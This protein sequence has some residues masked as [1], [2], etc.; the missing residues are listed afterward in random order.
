MR[1]CIAQFGIMRKDHSTMQLSDITGC[2]K[3]PFSTLKVLGARSTMSFS[4]ESIFDQSGSRRVA[5]NCSY[6]KRRI[7]H[8]YDAKQQS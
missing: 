8:C 7:L 1:S 4:R 2:D 6:C 3:I 5:N